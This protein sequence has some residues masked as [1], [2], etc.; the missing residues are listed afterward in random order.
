MSPVLS[1]GDYRVTRTRP[2]MPEHTPSMDSVEW[3]VQ[4]NRNLPARRKTLDAVGSPVVE[5]IARKK[6]QL[7]P[8]ADTLWKLLV[9]R[10]TTLV[11]RA[12]ETR[13]GDHAVVPLVLITTRAS[14]GV[15]RT[16]TR[17]VT[18]RNSRSVRRSTGRA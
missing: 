5:G 6:L 8:Y 14:A 4:R 1:A 16:A 10:H 17:S 15:A 9:A 13:A 3:I 2:H 18:A 12:T 7:P 11:P